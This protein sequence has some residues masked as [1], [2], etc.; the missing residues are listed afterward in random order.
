MQQSRS[1][2][3]TLILTVFV[4]LGLALASWAHPLPTPAEQRFEQVFEVLQAAGL[5][6]VEICGQTPGKKP[7]AEAPCPICR[8][9]AAPVDLAFALPPAVLLQPLYRQPLAQGRRVAT[10][11]LLFGQGAQGPPAAVI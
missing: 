7:C 9:S 5:P 6:M 8:G 11:R 1:R 10:E 2:L 3:M 4:G